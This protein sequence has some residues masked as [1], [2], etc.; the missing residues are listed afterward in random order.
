[1]RFG[2]ET[3]LGAILDPVADKLLLVGCFITLG[4]L[5]ILPWWLVLT[6]FARDLIIVVWI[7]SHH[8]LLENVEVVPSVL[9][10]INTFAQI[11][12]VLLVVYA[13]ANQV[14]PVF[15]DM[16]IVI[17]LLTTVFSGL[18]YLAIWSRRAAGLRQATR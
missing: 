6:V 15:I 1:K 12:C 17:T 2:W 13:A 5:G 4:W 18:Q 9:S 3:S 8:Y 7:V 11:V 14:A 16:W 10:K